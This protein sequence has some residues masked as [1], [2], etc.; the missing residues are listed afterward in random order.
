MMWNPFRN[1]GDKP[2]ECPLCGWQGMM[3]PSPPLNDAPCPECGTLMLPRS[4]M[5]TWGRTILILSLVV[6]AVL[7][8]AYF[9]QP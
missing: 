4:W 2:Y 1:L 8:V 5:D 6:A 9:G 7:F 3:E